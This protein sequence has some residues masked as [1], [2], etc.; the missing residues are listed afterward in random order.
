[1]EHGGLRVRLATAGDAA[2]VAAVYAPYVL[3]TAITFETVPPSV[4][5]I[6]GRIER[7]S[8]TH[9]FLVC[10]AGDA[11]LGYAYTSPH[12][13]RAAYRWATDCTVYVARDAQR[14][15]IGRALYTALLPITAARGY[16]AS[17]AGITQPNRSSV[18]LHEALGFRA[19]CVYRAVGHKLDAWH[20]VGWWVRELAP[21]A[22]QPPEPGSAPAEAVAAAL[23]AGTALLHRAS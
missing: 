3:E 6:R 22:A 9:A 17:Y 5:E 7:L 18:G 20:D 2:G 13:E 23:Q 10:A 21:R 14:R 11:I 19:L 12:R 15:G 8:A 1:V 4:E 16:V